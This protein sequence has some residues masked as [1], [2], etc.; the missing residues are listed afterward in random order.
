[1]VYLPIVQWI[2]QEP[3]KLL[4]GVRFPLGGPNF[5][6]PLLGAFVLS[7]HYKIFQFSYIYLLI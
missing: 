3:S 4:M 2:E 6:K 1:M 5:L 7:F